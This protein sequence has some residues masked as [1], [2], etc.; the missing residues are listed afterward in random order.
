MPGALAGFKKKES[1]F[2]DIVSYNLI[3]IFDWWPNFHVDNIYTV[4]SSL[5]EALPVAMAY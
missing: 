5:E 2:L 1:R 3:L 4:P